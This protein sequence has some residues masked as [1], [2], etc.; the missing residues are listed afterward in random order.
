[1]AYVTPGE[2][3]EASWQALTTETVLQARGPHGHWYFCP[4]LPVLQTLHG[5]KTRNVFLK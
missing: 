4:V 3:A 5:F 2:V 1:M